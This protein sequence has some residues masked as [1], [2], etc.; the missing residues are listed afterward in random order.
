MNLI[1][2]IMHTYNAN[3]YGRIPKKEKMLKRRKRFTFY[4]MELVLWNLNSFVNKSIFSL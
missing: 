3:P 1:I 4:N 2:S